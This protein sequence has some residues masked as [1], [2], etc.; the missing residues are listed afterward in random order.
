MGIT[1]DGSNLWVVNSR[2]NID[3]VFKYTLSGSLLGSWSIDDQNAT[4]EGITIDPT[5]V[6]SIWIADRGTG[7]VFEYKGGA[8]RTSGSQNADS[9]FDLA[10]TNADPRGIADPPA[11]RAP[12][13]DRLALHVE[14]RPISS[15]SVLGDKY[16]LSGSRLR[17]ESI[18]NESITPENITIDLTNIDS[19]WI[20]DP[21]TR[22]V[23]EY[24]DGANSM[25]VRRN[26]ASVFDLAANNVEPFGMADSP[27]AVSPLTNRSGPYFE[28]LI[29]NSSSVLDNL[30]A[31][32]IDELGDD[33]EA[34]WLRL[35]A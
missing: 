4:P 16:T 26:A 3:E 6:D 1:T 30:F 23:F 8:N 22:Q 34:V 9:V 33:P 20:A 18:N 25:L 5:N 21:G 32:W 14:Q 10:P 2:K 12:E 24:I 29:I 15:P 13:T 19:I 35:R 28:D 27:A 31:E 7:Q 11:A 17:S